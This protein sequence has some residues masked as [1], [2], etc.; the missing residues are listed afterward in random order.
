MSENQERGISREINGRKVVWGERVLK[1]QGGF[2]G[3]DNKK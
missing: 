3:R 1:E 2:M